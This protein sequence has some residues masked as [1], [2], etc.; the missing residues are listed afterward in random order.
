MNTPS[1]SPTIVNIINT[2]VPLISSLVKRVP[3]R[4]AQE[5]KLVEEPEEIDRGAE[6]FS[7]MVQIFLIFSIRNEGAKSVIQE[8]DIETHWTQ[9][10]ACIR[11]P[12]GRKTNFFHPNAGV[13]FPGRPG[14]PPLTPG[15]KVRKPT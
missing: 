8:S 12:S 1:A 10:S 7:K 11:S 2:G 14:E 6:T 15:L 13:R 4:F 3:K 5:L 9:K